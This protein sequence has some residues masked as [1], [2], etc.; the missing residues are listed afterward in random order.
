MVLVPQCSLFQ[1]SRA[2]YFLPLLQYS[3][4]MGSPIIPRNIFYKKTL[5]VFL[6]L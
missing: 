1:G 5:M 3:R 4:S 6:F 2:H